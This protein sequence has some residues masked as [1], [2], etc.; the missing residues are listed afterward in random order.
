MPRTVPVV[1]DG[2]LEF[3]A[4]FYA[5][6]A[7][8]A[9]RGLRD[10]LEEFPGRDEAIA[11]EY[12]R[13]TRSG[14]TGL[15]ATL[16]T[17]AGASSDRRS[18]ALPPEGSARYESQRVLYA[19]PQIEV[20]HCRDMAIDRDV[21]LV[22][23]TSTV[24][25]FIRRFHR[26]LLA[27]AKLSHPNIVPVHDVGHDECGRLFFVCDPTTG[28]D[29]GR[30]VDRTDVSGFAKLSIL[31]Q[32]ALT[33]DY[34]HRRG[35]VHGSLGGGS[36]AAGGSIRIGEFGEVTIG[37]WYESAVVG[38]AV[39]RADDVKSLAKLLDQIGKA[40]DQRPPLADASI[41]GLVD[42][43]RETIERL[44]LRCHGGSRVKAEHVA[45]IVQQVLDGATDRERR[46]RGAKSALSTARDR[47]NDRNR[48]ASRHD[49]ALDAARLTATA[50]WRKIAEKRPY[51]KLLGQVDRTRRESERCRNEAILA[52]EAAHRWNPDDATTVDA[53]VDR[54]RELFESGEATGDDSEVAFAEGRLRA[55]DRPDVNAW[56][57]GA[58]TLTLRFGREPDRVTVRRLSDHDRRL[59]PRGRKRK[60]VGPSWTWPE[61]P[62]GSYEAT[63]EREGSDPV[64]VPL[65]IARG[66]RCETTI[67]LELGRD[68]ATGFRRIY[69]GETIV[70]GDRSTHDSL[71][72]GTVTVPEFAM[73]EYPVTCG[74]Y[75]E[76]LTTLIGSRS[77]ETRIPRWDQEPLDWFDVGR[78]VV[79]V[80]VQHQAKPVVGITWHS[81]TAYAKWRSTTDGRRYRLPSDLQWEAAARGVDG[82]WYPW[83]NAFDASFCKCAASRPGEPKIE[84]VGRFRADLSPY[85][86][87]DLA[88]GVMDWCRSWFSESSQQRLIRGGAWQRAPIAS[89][90]AYRAGAPP[91][92]SYPFVGMR[93]V[94][95]VEAR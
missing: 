3:V 91:G 50:P 87:R 17:F 70:G 66:A 46:E 94:H 54:Y 1:F 10:Y 77:L 68:L 53:L 41:R 27:C 62:M 90:C 9:T 65:Y 76:Y 8:G 75:A 4:K 86:V 42:A 85:G 60:L 7:G 19:N 82:R 78:N 38:G 63:I 11:R 24:K 14:G 33:L 23:L 52:L 69:T 2:V 40:E 59:V 47:T 21:H 57:A 25:P 28:A 13:L 6:R 49:E 39:R 15:P 29:L 80:P 48:W 79:T 67:R 93:L 34:A 71:P 45:D 83:G 18:G 5:D 35:V 56:L 81:A 84:R 55:F 16:S 92:H 58:G 88:G 72:S 37:G 61:I 95:D 32:V 64:R 12:L 20:V 36:P 44:S 22:L 89:R 74:E 51:W 73:S 43:D 26:R 30:Y 31:R